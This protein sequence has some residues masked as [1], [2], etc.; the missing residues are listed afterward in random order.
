MFY[1]LEI[2]NVGS[3]GPVKYFKQNRAELNLPAFLLSSYVYYK[4]H[5]THNKA[6]IRPISTYLAV[7]ELERQVTDNGVDRLG[8][9][10][11]TLSQEYWCP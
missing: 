9:P 5:I 6:I 11:Y 1:I 2:K 8:E 3:R 10:G 4:S 7:L